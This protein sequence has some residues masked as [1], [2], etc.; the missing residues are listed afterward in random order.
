MIMLKLLGWYLIDNV[1]CDHSV[2]IQNQFANFICWL[3]LK[4][5]RYPIYNRLLLNKFNNRYIWTICKEVKSFSVLSPSVY[6]SFCF[7]FYFH[8][9][10]DLST[11]NC[12]LAF[13]C[14]LMQFVTVNMPYLVQS[15][16]QSLTLSKCACIIYINTRLTD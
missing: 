15:I 16:E 3:S 1:Y 2:E 14:S 9:N 6:C 5:N 7:R 11:L 12:N 4:R 13:D 10:I 8:L